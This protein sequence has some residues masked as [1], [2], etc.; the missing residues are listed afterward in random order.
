MNK[1]LIVGGVILFIVGVVASSSL[2]IVEQTQ[3]AIVLFFGKPQKTIQDPGLY[4]KIPFGEEVV[5]YDKRVLDLDPP[6][7]RMILADQKRLDVDSYARYRIVDPL[8]FYQTTRRVTEVSGKMSPII[9]SS[10]R[11]VLGNETLLEILSGK[12]AEIMVDIQKAVNDAVMRFGMEIVEVRVRRADYPEETRS[13]IENRM[14][15]ER[16]REAKEFR[17]RGFEMAEGIRADAGKQKIVLLAQA[18]K[19][20]ETLRGEGDGLAIKIYADAFGQDPEFFAFY[21][22]MQA[23]KKSM[24]SQDTTMVLS[25]NSD[26]FRFFGDITGRGVAKK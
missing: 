3:Q 5:Y 18:Q 13:N 7:E 10:L 14:K 6:K 2:F 22:S 25:P 24:D 26:F 4:F 17:A 11:R 23:Y 1:L 21:R 20:A 9:N 12:R 8:L 15:S 16:E 19:K